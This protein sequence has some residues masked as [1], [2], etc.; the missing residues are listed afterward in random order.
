MQSLR[1]PD[2]TKFPS[3]QGAVYKTAVLRSP[4]VK[5]KTHKEQVLISSRLK[6]VKGL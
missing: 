3:E 2:N 4:N 5:F 1:L 6:E